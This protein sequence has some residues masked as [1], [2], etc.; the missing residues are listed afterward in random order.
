MALI[1]LAVLA[2]GALFPK[3]FSPKLRYIAWIV[4]LFGLI[5]PFRPLFG[6][7]LVTIQMPHNFPVESQRQT[8]NLDGTVAEPS[9]TEGY[10]QS[11]TDYESDT[12]SNLPITQGISIIYVLVTAWGMVALA[13]LSYQIWRYIR[14]KKLIRRWSSAQTDEYALTILQD[15]Q[16]D[17][18]IANKKI[19][20]RKCDFISTS[21]IVGFLHPVILLPD[22]DFNADELELIFRHELIHYKRG[23]LFIKLLSVI[24]ISFNWFNPAVYL[25]N[26]TMQAD[27][28]AS[29]DEA[30][31]AEIGGEN[32]QFY[33]E[34]IIDMIGSKKSN[35]IMLSTC[36]Y[37][38]KN[39]IRKRM[40]AI[41]NSANVAKKISFSVILAL[42]V[43]I[44]LTGSIFAF[45]NQRPPEQT[46]HHMSQYPITNYSVTD[47]ESSTRQITSHRAREIAVEFVGHGEIQD[48]RA[49]TEDGLLNF[50]VE[51]GQGMILYIVRINGESGD[52][53]SLARY[54]TEYI[55]AQDPEEAELA[56]PTQLITPEPSH[57]SIPQP[58]P[59]PVPESTPEPTNIPAH[60][61]DNRPS[62]PAISLER[63]VEIAYADL[64]DRGINATYR[65]NSGMDWER[66]QWVWE[67]LFRTQGERMPFIEFYINVD[68]GNIVKFEWDD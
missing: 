7:G 10:E 51:V 4:I 17:K 28:E 3:I 55:T 22:K 1:I 53:I 16:A 61:R 12:Q 57:T 52:I 64:A 19:G 58:T 24:A 46:P 66:G 49:F 20:L 44:V 11:I 54:T 39:G 36:F 13:I 47:S 45:S 56:T 25:M 60:N 33:A 63:A 6:N 67:L 35:G 21:M 38:S 14:F 15:I 43:L 41:M 59:E 65:S 30:V 42:I 5:I 2:L 8:S 32:R 29:C 9:I 68:T 34:T 50:E 23:D 27:C 40:E 26:I 37:G 48:I 18:G 62:N 31:I